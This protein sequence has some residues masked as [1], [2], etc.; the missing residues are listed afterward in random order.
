MRET[1]ALSDQWLASLAA[2]LRRHDFANRAVACLGHPSAAAIRRLVRDISAEAPA[3]PAPTD[4]AGILIEMLL[5]GRPCSAEAGAMLLGQSLLESMI[6]NGLLVRSNGMVASNAYMLVPFHD[7]LFFVSRLRHEK[8]QPHSIAVYIGRDTEE[9]TSAAL[10]NAGKRTLDLGCGGGLVGI[11]LAAERPGTEVVG[12]DLC[13]QAVAIAAINA[14]LNDIAYVVRT[15][16]LYAPVANERFDLIV[17]DP[18]A[19]ALPAELASPIYGSGGE[20]GDDLLRRMVSGLDRHLADG[21]QFIAITELQS[22]AAPP[23]FAAWARAWSAKHPEFTVELRYVASRRLPPSYH[24]SLGANLMY[25]PGTNGCAS[26]LSRQRLVAF[27][28]RQRVLF[29]NWTHLRIARRT[30]KVCFRQIFDYPR[31]QPISRPR[32][33]GPAGHAEAQLALHYPGEIGAFGPHLQ[34]FL[35]LCTGR[36]TLASIAEQVAH[37]LTDELDFAP[38]ECLHYLLRLTT[39]LAQISV[40]EA[41]DDAVA[42][43]AAK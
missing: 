11:T 40:L 42:M 43:G 19:V 12:T 17:A 21:G 38:D 28:R 7:R 16:D 13:E 8:T 1:A 3:G 35:R 9:L 24:A 20:S 25:L 31:A 39:A 29:G 15:G 23:C 6:A 30:E 33:A 26:T 2:I 5:F 34:S 22:T 14:R 32:R 36:Q 27:A 41:P 18:P 10:A 37:E 4:D